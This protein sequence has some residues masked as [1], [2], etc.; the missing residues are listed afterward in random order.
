MREREN[1]GDNMAQKNN[2]QTLRDE[3]SKNWRIPGIPYL[4][5]GAVI[6][7]PQHTAA[8]NTILLSALK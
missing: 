2:I 6:H 3:N 7:N 4:I 8:R 5:L 1:T